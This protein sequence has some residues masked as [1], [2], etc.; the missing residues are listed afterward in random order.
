MTRIG[1]YALLSDCQS[2]AL[3]SMAATME[4]RVASRLSKRHDVD[5][6]FR[7]RA[8]RARSR[9]LDTGTVSP[10]AAPDAVDQHPL[11]RS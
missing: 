11:V 3:V 5:R 4:W 2:G 1:E 8:R 7:R 6:C 10:A 9:G